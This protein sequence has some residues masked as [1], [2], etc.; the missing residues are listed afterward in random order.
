MAVAVCVCVHLK[1]PHG[2]FQRWMIY[3]KCFIET[4]WK[5]KRGQ[6]A[7]GRGK[8]EGEGKGGTKTLT[9]LQTLEIFD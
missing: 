3:R 7:R 1:G 6:E 5:W 2:Y 8:E 9:V 4:F